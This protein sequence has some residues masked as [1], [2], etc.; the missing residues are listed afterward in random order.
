MI[1]HVCLK[2]IKKGKKA[3]AKRMR[4]GKLHNGQGQFIHVKC[5]DVWR[6]KERLLQSKGGLNTWK[7]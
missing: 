2:R 4:I 7:N 1:C 3:A 5:L 6:I